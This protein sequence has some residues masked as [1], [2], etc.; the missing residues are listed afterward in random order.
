VGLYSPGYTWL[1]ADLGHRPPDFIW[2]ILDIV[3]FCCQGQGQLRIIVLKGLF[4]LPDERKALDLGRTP[5][6]GDLLLSR[7]VSLSLGDLALVEYGHGQA[8]A[9]YRGYHQDGGDKL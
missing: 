2:R 8:D 3:S 6:G 9:E 7:V 1:K 5:F 4:G